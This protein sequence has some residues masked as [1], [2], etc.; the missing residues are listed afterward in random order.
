MG[1]LANAKS[2]QAVPVSMEDEEEHRRKLAS[3]VNNLSQGKGNFTGLATLNAAGATSTTVS[4]ARCGPNSVIL[5]MP[6]GDRAAA[7]LD[8]WAVQTRAKGSF[9]VTSPAGGTTSCTFAYAIFG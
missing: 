9:T 1:S 2:Y 3:I 6:V 7:A 4:D 5:I 8:T